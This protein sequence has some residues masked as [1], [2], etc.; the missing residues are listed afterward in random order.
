MKLS[1]NT[2]TKRIDFHLTTSLSLSLSPI[3]S[4]PPRDVRSPRSPRWNAPRVPAQRWK[5]C[6]AYLWWQRD[7]ENVWNCQKPGILLVI[8]NLYSIPKACICNAILLQGPFGANPKKILTSSNLMNSWSR[9]TKSS[10]MGPIHAHKCATWAKWQRCATKHAMYILATQR[11][12]SLGPAL[13]EAT[14]IKEAFGFSNESKRWRWGSHIS[15]YKP[16][17]G[18]RPTWWLNQPVQKI[19][20]KLDHFNR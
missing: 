19:L 15:L 18:C 13:L 10:G 16:S 9:N 14:S 4:S 12:L 2:K 11:A 8:C 6:G 1:W 17:L 3:F 7:D 20:V 5:Q